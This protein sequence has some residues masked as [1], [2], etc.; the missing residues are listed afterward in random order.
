[1]V[2]RLIITASGGPFRSWTREQIEQATV[3]DALK[4]PN[5]NM[6][7]KITIDSA[8]MLNKAFEIIEARWLFGISPDRITALVHPQSIV[9]SMVEYVDGAIKAQLGTPDMRL[10]IAYALGEA[11]RDDYALPPLTLDKMR[12]LTFMEPDPEKFPCLGFA[13]T[14]LQRGGNVACV[15]NAANE[16]AVAALLAGRI[17]YVDIYDVIAET[18]ER[19]SFIASPGYDDYVAT[20]IAARATAES[21]IKN[22]Q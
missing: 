19:S 1:K 6:G 3:A 4:H 7:A 11:T 21:I 9:H 20:N 22:M 2:R 13:Y 10:P 16:V 15:I 17:R 8:T 5:W 14:A 12:E 18:L